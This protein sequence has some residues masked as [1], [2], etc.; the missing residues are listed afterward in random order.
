MVLLV[1][2]DQAASG[3]TTYGYLNAKL[4][5]FCP[6]SLTDLISFLS[7]ADLGIICLNFCP[8]ICSM[9]CHVPDFERRAMHVL[10]HVL[11]VLRACHT[12]AMFVPS[13]MFAPSPSPSPADI[14]LPAQACAAINSTTSSTGSLRSLKPPHHRQP[15]SG[16]SC[17]SRCWW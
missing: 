17:A 16:S 3:N 9:S 12:R 2:S 5:N 14:G 15:P 13:N 11:T 4:N 7:K 10:L 1:G 8:S 6:F